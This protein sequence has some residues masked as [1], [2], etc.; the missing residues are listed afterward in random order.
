M[1]LYIMYVCIYA[2]VMDAMKCDQEQVA[3]P[4]M[5]NSGTH[6]N[7]DK[8]SSPTKFHPNHQHPDLNSSRLKIPTEYI[9]MFIHDHL[10]NGDR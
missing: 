1:L 9:G 4:I 10:A 6:M 5:A 3:K 7:V 2:C 8:V